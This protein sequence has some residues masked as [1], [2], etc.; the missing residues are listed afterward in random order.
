MVGGTLVGLFIT[1]KTA[2]LPRIIIYADTNGTAFLGGIPLVTTNVRN[3]TFK[4][5][6]AVGFKAG[7]AIPPTINNQAQQREML[8]TLKSMAR[9]G[10]LDTNPPPTSAYE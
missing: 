4:A 7:L 2:P 6:G 10:L 3:A 1:P 5:I 8:Q 9:A